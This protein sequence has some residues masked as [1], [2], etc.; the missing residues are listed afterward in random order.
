MPLPS[1]TKYRYKKG[2]S[3]R[4]AFQGNKV[5][6]AKNMDSGDT[7]MMGGNIGPEMMARK[8][9]RGLRESM[10]GYNHG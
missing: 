6:E 10:M 5:V 1:G 7:A 9:K 8:K 2:S 3:L 4:L